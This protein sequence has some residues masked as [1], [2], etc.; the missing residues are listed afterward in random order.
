MKLRRFI[1]YTLFIFL[2]TQT[3]NAETGFYQL[4]REPLIRIGLSTNASYVS[5]TTTD[6]QLIAASPDEAKRFLATNKITVSARSYRPPEIEIYNFEIQNLESAD[7]AASL[8]KDIRETTGEKTSFEL[9]AKTNTW[10]IRVG[11]AK[12][13]IEEADEFKGILEE[14]GVADVTIVTEKIT[15][16]SDEAVK[17]SNQIAQNPKSEVRSLEVGRPRVDRFKS[18]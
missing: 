7:E 5:I 14:K 3:L 6:T 8:A 4:T 16:P 10:K 2:T 13:S 17:L 1:F 12:N 15:R 18:E 11:E 9:D